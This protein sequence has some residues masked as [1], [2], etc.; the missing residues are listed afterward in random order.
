MNWK[1]PGFAHGRVAGGGSY[2]EER[3]RGFR[4]Y[5]FRNFPF[6]GVR[7]GGGAHQEGIGRRSP[8]LLFRPFP[9]RSSR[10]RCPNDEDDSIRKGGQAHFSS[11]R[12]PSSSRPP[13]FPAKT[14]TLHSTPLSSSPLSPNTQR[15]D[16]TERERERDRFPR[17]RLH[18]W[19]S[20]DRRGRKRVGR[21]REG[22]EEDIR[23]SM[24]YKLR[25][26]VQII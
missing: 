22:E 21:G 24:M 12:F 18:H 13:G 11:F 10:P 19:Q 20:A 26:I 4:C 2:C 15:R 6:N 25:C 7:V 9:A 1:P 23:N 17:D 8:L 16:W 5:I 3:L 14:H